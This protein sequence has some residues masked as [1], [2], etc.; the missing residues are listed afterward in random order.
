MRENT[1]LEDMLLLMT[2]HHPR[3]LSGNVAEQSQSSTKAADTNI[4]VLV[5]PTFRD[6]EITYIESSL[7]VYC[8]FTSDFP[9][10]NLVIFVL[11]IAVGTDDAFLLFSHFPQNLK[12]ES[13]YECLA[14]TSSTM[15]LTSFSTAVPFFVN[16][17]SN[18]VVFRCF[19]LFA[20]VT[21]LINY[22][23]VISLLPAFLILQN[24]FSFLFSTKIENG[25]YLW[26]PLLTLIVVFSSVVAIKDL[27]LPEYNPLQL[28]EK[29]AIPLFARLVW[30]VKKVNSTAM[31]RPDAVTPLEALA[32]TLATYR[33]FPFI[34][35]SEPF[36]PE[37]F[38]DWSNR[39]HC[40]EG[41]VCCNMSNSLFNNA[42]LDYCL[43][44]STSYIFT[45]YNDTPLF[46]NNSFALSGYTAMLPTHL[47]YS[48]R[49]HRLSQTFSRLSSLSP[50]HGWWAPEWAIISTWYDL[51]RSI[52][53]DVRSSVIVSVAVVALFSLIQ[54]KVQAIAAVTSCVCIIACSVGTVALLG[55]EIGVLEAVIL[56]L[57][58]GLSF[59]YTLHYGAALPATGCKSH[60]I[61]RAAQM[62]AVPVALSASTSFLAGAA[63]LFSQTHAFFQVGV[64]LIV[65]TACS[66]V[67]A[68]FFFLPLLFLSL[69]SSKHCDDCDRAAAR[70]FPMDEKRSF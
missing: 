56:V 12:E 24:R 58:V 52:V 27:H 11:L 22:I 36:W 30:G 68:T 29:I 44:N 35:H 7:G 21:I 16:I 23:L 43:R 28:F 63:M 66:W 40:S 17:A 59:D 49:F 70:T 10:L 48:H 53:S 2:P 60:K 33:N 9:L 31:F 50:D 39:Y 38:I 51:Q 8:L 45:S 41:F 65:I 14:H 64:F 3:I 34:N 4:M 26:L 25:K 55:W 15:F 47:S 5:P 18:V 6:F 42:F 19:G 61:Q 62:A 13:F 1:D 46:D 37:K 20:G 54:L 32:T 67:F 57:V 69:R